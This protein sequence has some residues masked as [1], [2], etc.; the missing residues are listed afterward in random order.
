MI[1]MRNSTSFLSGPRLVPVLIKFNIAAR[2]AQ[3]MHLT[4]VL[5]AA[6]KKLAL[7]LRIIHRTK[8]LELHRCV[9]KSGSS[10]PRFMLFFQVM[11][12]S[13]GA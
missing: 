12:I 10:V 2:A 13:S 4:D 3:S 1:G 7:E 8:F 6:V 11:Y 5:N 9:A